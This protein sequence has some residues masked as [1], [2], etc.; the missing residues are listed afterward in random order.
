MLV[1]Y[2]ADFICQ[3]ITLEASE[4][5]ILC[6]LLCIRSLELPFNSFT[7]QGG[8]VR[9]A[10]IPDLVHEVLIFELIKELL[11]GA[12]IGEV[13]SRLECIMEVVVAWEFFLIAILCRLCKLL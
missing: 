12:G 7:I 2:L 10:F 11:L 6:K 13:Q 8:V 9:H 3:S 4:S 5:S 1:E